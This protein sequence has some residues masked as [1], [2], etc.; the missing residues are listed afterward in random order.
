MAKPLLA[1]DVDGVVILMGQDDSGGPPVQIELID[2]MMRAVSLSAGDCLRRLAPHYELLWAS[3]WEDRANRHLPALLG[4]ERLPFLSFDGAARFGTAEWKLGPLGDYCRDR[5]LAWL[6][7]C[8]DESCQ[9]WAE[10]R[11]AP[12][13][14]VAVDPAR[15]LEAA[16]VDALI[17]WANEL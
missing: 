17:A 5:P 16:H 13:K 15:G 3:G 7:D 14:L 10:E 6:D 1:V 2:G 12:T 4:I 9:R 8:I 11:S